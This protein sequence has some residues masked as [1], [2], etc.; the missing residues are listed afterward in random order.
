MP[1]TSEQ[2][3]DAQYSVL[4]SA[5]I[6]PELVPVVLAETTA[7]DY[8]GG[9]RAV[10]GAMAALMGS[11]GTVDVVTISDKLGSQY[12]ELL[13]GMMDITPTAAH[14][15]SYIRLVKQASRL[16]RVREL[17]S[18]LSAAETL[19]AAEDPVQQLNAIY[20]NRQQSKAQTPADLLRGFMTRKT[21][22]ISYLA[23]PIPELNRELFAKGGSYIV[24]GGYP[25]SGKTAFALQCLWQWAA[26]QKVVFFSLETDPETLYDRM[27]SG[28]AGI[29]MV[30][31][32]RG[33]LND[34]QWAQ[35]A[36]C[37]TELTQRSFLL[38]PAAGYTVAQIQAA[39]TMEQADI[40]IIDY[41]QLIRAR[42][43]SRYDQ[44]TQISMDLHTMAQRTGKIVVALAQLARGEKNTEPS[45]SSLKE[46]GQIE[47]DAD[48][49]LLM[50]EPVKGQEPFDRWLRIAKNKEG[51]RSR[52]PLAFDG[53]HQT[54]CKAMDPET[55]RFLDGLKQ[56]RKNKHPT[57]VIGQPKVE[58]FE[59]LPMDTEVPF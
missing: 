53:A 56:G 31:I 17:G 5:L 3:L 41:I 27:I 15:D 34:G 51:E 47:Q 48:I 24:L 39:A 46:S 20:A 32:K 54:F 13:M 30:N 19:E 1:V 14:L 50:Y 59:Q 52:I 18:Q 22:A 2:W 49:V 44:V 40:V 16:L 23:W 36:S 8:S 26:S 33:K 57:P 21:Q 37:S 28:I 42:G 10:Y 9:C 6:E 11:G 29:P 25:S 38:V 55:K 35:I 58:D 4:G 7:S 12:R 45:M 43:N